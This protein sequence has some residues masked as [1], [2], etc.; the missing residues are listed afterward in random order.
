MVGP[1][2][3]PAS[4]ISALS[5]LRL[6]MVRSLNASNVLFRW[7][8]HHWQNFEGQFRYKRRNR[9]LLTSCD[10]HGVCSLPL[11][12]YSYLRNG[13]RSRMEPFR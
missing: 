5:V 11:G 8:D 3:Q 7:S 4:L 10:S 12:L 6:V 2:N 13:G 9:A 1:G